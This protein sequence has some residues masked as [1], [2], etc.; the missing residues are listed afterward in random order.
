MAVY[1]ECY[2]TKSRY[3]RK[4][5]ENWWEAVTLRF[6][7]TDNLVT[8]V[9]VINIILRE[10]SATDRWITLQMNLFILYIDCEVGL[11]F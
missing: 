10:M 3:K 6:M 8:I 11:S 5:H 7:G 1:P 9:S 4:L 2:L